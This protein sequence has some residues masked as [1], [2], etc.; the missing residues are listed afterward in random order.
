MKFAVALLWLSLAA[1]RAPVRGK[2]RE[3]QHVSELLK[4]SGV[5]EQCR[6]I[7]IRTNVEVNEGAEA[8]EPLVRIWIKDDQ[9]A[10]LR[11]VTVSLTQRDWSVWPGRGS[12]V[13][14]W[15]KP[16]TNTRLA[17]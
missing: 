12:T 3:K 1:G 7:C 2:N 17:A 10:A 6:Y 4:R 9:T 5:S 14:V 13:S 16:L 11:R 15:R 8:F